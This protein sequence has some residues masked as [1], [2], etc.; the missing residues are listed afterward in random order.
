MLKHALLNWKTSV[1]A[2][3]TF[4]IA[5]LTTATAFQIPSF[6]NTNA[7]H[8]WMYFTVGA[9]FAV[10]MFKVWL[11]LIQS[12][13]PP[14]PPSSPTIPPAAALFI[15]VALGCLS[16]PARAQSPVSAPAATATPV[17][18]TNVYA[19]GPSYNFGGTP[20]VAGT[21]LYAHLL[22]TGSNTWAF[23]A[24][25]ILPNSV[26]PFTVNT[27][28]AAGV[29]QQ[30]FKIGSVPIY[31]PTAAGISFQGPNTGW[32]WNTGALADVKIKGNWHAMLGGRVVKS[33]VS[34]GTGY[35]PIATVLIAWEQ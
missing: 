7:S 17:A 20:A 28:I 30:I 14:N 26:K 34:N 2:I 15:L 22:P 4:L 24:V 32:E 9:N 10:T 19:V 6:F 18:A 12:D 3:L 35:Q 33:S 11:G 25:D 21:G 31:V 29:A 8:V 13:A 27:N 16:F 5:T 23:T 1:S